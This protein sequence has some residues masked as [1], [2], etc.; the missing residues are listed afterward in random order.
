MVINFWKCFTL[1]LN[2]FTPFNNIKPSSTRDGSRVF[3]QR[4]SRCI[5]VKLL[6]RTSQVWKTFL[7]PGCIKEDSWRFFS[8]ISHLYPYYY[9]NSLKQTYFHTQWDL[10][11]LAVLLFT[12]QNHFPILFSSQ[13]NLQKNLSKNFTKKTV[14]SLPLQLICKC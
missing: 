1:F 6:V 3:C 4:T 7:S 5:E 13:K 10:A 12:Y 9:I 11:S 14:S 8:F 2:N